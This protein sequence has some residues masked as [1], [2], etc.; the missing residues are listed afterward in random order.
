MQAMTE[1]TFER[2]CNRSQR[3]ARLAQVLLCAVAL[4]AHGAPALAAGTAHTHTV[5]IEATSYAPQAL[6][7]KRGDTVVWVNKDPFPHTATSAGAFDSK[8][9]AAGASWKY[10][11]NK[12]GVYPYTC[13]FH[14]NMKATLTVE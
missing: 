14:P 6:S 10:K 1:C 8:S 4:T 2:R 11:A 5:V 12:A 13:T 7:V 9:I 3:T